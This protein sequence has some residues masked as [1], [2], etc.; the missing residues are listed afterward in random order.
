MRVKAALYTF[1]GHQPQETRVRMVTMSKSNLAS[2]GFSNHEAALVQATKAIEDLTKAVVE[3]MEVRGG[4]MRKGGA[5]TATDPLELSSAIWEAGV[6]TGLA[7]DVVRDALSSGP[8]DVQVGI[9]SQ[10]H[11]SAIESQTQIRV[12]CHDLYD[13]K[14]TPIDMNERQLERIVKYILVA[15]NS[16][17]YLAR[18]VPSLRYGL[19]RAAPNTMTPTDEELGRPNTMTPTEEEWKAMAD[20]LVGASERLKETSI[21]MDMIAQTR[22]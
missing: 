2:R 20:K 4:I 19:G 9:L 6:Q 14:D 18:S 15:G 8:A 22:R 12:L 16:I 17:Q 21:Y 11:S 5:T 10:L 7:A 3:V 13:N 1:I